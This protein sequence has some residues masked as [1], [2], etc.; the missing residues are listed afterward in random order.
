MGLTNTPGESQV[1][2]VRQRRVF[3]LRFEDPDMAGLVVRARSISLGQFLDVVGLRDADPR[4]MAR[5]DLDKLFA[6]FAGALLDWN[7]EEPEGTPVPATLEGLHGLE[8][9]FVMAIIAAWL[10]AMAGVARPL[11]AA[12][13]NGDRSLEAS[14]PMEVQSPSLQS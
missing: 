2:Y 13:S 8:P 1:G 10:D 6:A 11:G 14:M 9:D 5:T 12:S 7:L 3:R 4:Q